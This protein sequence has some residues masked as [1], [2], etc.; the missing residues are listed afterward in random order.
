MVKIK[1]LDKDTA[2]QIAAGEVI[3]NPSSVVKELVENALDAGSTRIE[4]VLDEGG[5]K[6]I[7]VT[8]NGHG[9]APADLALAFQRFATSKLN[10]FD[11]LSR[12]KSLG[13][14]G[15]ALPS[16]AAVSRIKVTARAENSI[17]ASAISLSG[18]KITEQIETG[19][20]YGTRVE[21][22][23][24]FYNTPGRLKFLRAAMFETSRIST[25]L[26]E[27][28]L[29]NPGV[30]FD[31]KSKGRTLFR[32]AGDGNLL[33]TIGS[34]YGNETAGEM[35]ELNRV[36]K[37]SGASVS[38]YTS[39]PHTTRSSRKWITIVVNGRLIKNAM[40]V[41][42]IERAYGDLLPVR[43]H[44]ITILHIN[45]PPHTIDVNVHPAKTEIRFEHPETAKNLVYKAVKNTSQSSSNL[46]SW[47]ESISESGFKSADQLDQLNMIRESSFSGIPFKY[48]LFL[49]KNQGSAEDIDY[50]PEPERDCPE[51]L[52]EAGSCRLIGQYLNSYLVVQRDDNLLLIDQH[53]AHERVIY[54]RL[55]TEDNIKGKTGSS[56]LTIPLTIELPPKWRQKALDILPDLKNF[57]FEIEPL[58]EDSYVVRAVPF[59]LKSNPG[60]SEIYDMLEKLFETEE[61]DEVTTKDI[62]SKTVACHRSVKAKQK[63]AWEE[64][65]ELLKNWENT[66]NAQYCPHGRPTVISF[67]RS[68]LEKGFHRGGEP[69]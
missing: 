3:E 20:P 59:M 30:S 5:K 52:N 18:G 56:Q 69:I 7:T 53:A 51:R 13:F 68:R 31:L 50:Q 44:P 62:V 55:S 9:M 61:I 16:I 33:H 45:L 35:Q 2:E 65:L 64:M 60:S 57:G 15:E 54:H 42:A 47:P 36:D 24:L 4:V 22:S 11:D 39:A 48:E 21:V 17:S 32:S 8:D 67:D 46:P 12:L 1:I 28:A 27:I 63:L 6:L 25:L 14:R 26:A 43:R 34:V 38:G 37:E 58:G 40:L 23:D 19:A 29:A 49:K 10:S 41:N 66:P